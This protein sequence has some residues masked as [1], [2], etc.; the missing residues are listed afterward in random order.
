MGFPRQGSWSGFPFPLPGYLPHLGFE[1]VSPALAGRFFTTEP[2]RKPRNQGI[3]GHLA[4]SSRIPLQLIS[5][6]IELYWK[7]P[8]AFYRPKGQRMRPDKGEPRRGQPA[9]LSFYGPFSRVSSCRP[10]FSVHLAAW[11]FSSLLY[12]EQVASPKWAWSL[13][14]KAM[15]PALGNTVQART[16]PMESRASCCIPGAQNGTWLI[17]YL[18]SSICICGCT[19]LT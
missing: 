17:R 13:S 18:W 1:P 14:P 9:D 5:A 19:Q 16:F 15:G 10:A 2:P 6:K 12:P 11:W 7:Q 3:S 8:G 4:A